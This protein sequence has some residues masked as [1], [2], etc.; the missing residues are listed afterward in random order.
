M[1]TNTQTRQELKQ[2][3]RALNDDI[4]INRV[5]E[6]PVSKVWA[7]WTQPEQFKKWWG[8]EGYTCPVSNMESKVGGRYLSC[9]KAPDGKEFWSTGVIKEFVPN[10]RLV[11]SDSFSDSKGNVISAADLGFPG[12]WPKELLIAVELKELESNT[13]QLTL[14]HEGI[15][16]EMREECISGWN[17]SLDKLERNIK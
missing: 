10:R 5:I 2:Q 16:E 12:N 11:V 6:L 3:K 14:R 15:P 1:E 9:M 4:V 13:T 7:A 17:Q 8:P